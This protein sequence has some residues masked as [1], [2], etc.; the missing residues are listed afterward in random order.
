MIKLKNTTI[1]LLFICGAC[2]S[3]SS[4]SKEEF[5]KEILFGKWVQPI[6]GQENENQGFQLNEDG[7][8]NSLNM[9][10]LLY[11]KWKLSKDTL[12]LWNHTVGVKEV[13]ANI[14]SL[15]IKKVSD[16]ELIIAPI[17]MKRVEE[18]Y[19]KE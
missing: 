17:N 6:P 8:A 12:F 5:S 15:L 19:I 16:V 4:K 14:D 10:T 11:D 1:A 13:S 18:R 3:P 7:T 9:H 2:Q